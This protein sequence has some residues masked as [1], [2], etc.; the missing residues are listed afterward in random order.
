MLQSKQTV[1]SN[2]SAI[3]TPLTYDG[4]CDSMPTTI[5]CVGSNH[6]RNRSQPIR[7]TR[8]MS[9]SEIELQEGILIAEYI[10]YCM[11]Q[12]I[13]GHQLSVMSSKDSQMNGG[14]QHNHLVIDNSSLPCNW[15]VGDENSEPASESSLSALIQESI[16]IQRVPFQTLLDIREPSHLWSQNSALT[17]NAIHVDD[18][19]FIFDME[20]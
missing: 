9:N 8:R 13:R 3:N 19:D 16:D 1:L 15:D 10:D 2:Y 18:M 7:F 6:S 11:F 12:R 17:T 5:N 20:L 4:K 14:A